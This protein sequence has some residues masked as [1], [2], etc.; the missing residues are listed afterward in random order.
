MR[1]EP[2]K[3]AGLDCFGTREKTT[4]RENSSYRTATAREMPLTF[5]CLDDFLVGILHRG[6]EHATRGI[7]VIVGGPQYRVGSHR[8]FVLFARCLAEAGIPVFRFDYRGMGDSEGETR[9]FESIEGDIRAAIDTFL[10]AAP[11]LREIVIWGLC[12]AASAACFYAP[13]DSRVAGLVMLNPWVRTEQG[14]AT[15][16]LKHYYLRRLVSGDFWRKIWRLEFGYTDSL[17]SFKG[18][19]RKANSSRGRIKEGDSEKTASLPSRAYDALAQF[20]GRV[21]FILSGKDLTADEFR[22]VIS[23]SPAWRKLLSSTN[24]E[25]RELSAADHTFSRRIWRDQVAEWTLAWVRSW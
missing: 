20:Q 11:G 24:I 4:L 7:L 9:T 6:S 25:R 17:R 12:D 18:L 22:D 15:V 1:E 8:Q 19:L 13:S 10:E 16:Y 3:Q 23:S 5:R 14:L 2:F 21:L